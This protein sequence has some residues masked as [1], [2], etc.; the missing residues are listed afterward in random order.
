M[1]K[2]KSNYGDYI[3]KNLS[4]ELTKEY[5]KEFSSTNLKMMRRLYNEYRNGQTLSGKLSWSH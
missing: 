1:R 2:D 4:K 3:I 5:G